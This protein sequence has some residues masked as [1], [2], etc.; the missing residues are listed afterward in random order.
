MQEGYGWISDRLPDQAFGVLVFIPF[1]YGFAV[2]EEF[3][4][5]LYFAIDEM[6]EGVDPAEGRQWLQKEQI[7]AVSLSYVV[8]LVS[9]YLSAQR[10]VPVQLNVPEDPVEKGEGGAGVCG[11]EQADISQ[12]DHGAGPYQQLDRTQLPEEE[13]EEHQG[14]QGIGDGDQHRPVCC[15]GPEAGG[16][17]I[18]FVPLAFLWRCAGDPRQG[19]DTLASLPKVAA[20][21]E[22][23]KR[24][25]QSQQGDAQQEAPVKA[26]E[27]PVGQEYPV[28][29]E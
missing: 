3:M 24:E 25:G 2:G 18:C 26:M 13:I 21:G 20:E 6:K 16:C 14:Y 15:G 19:R 5:D 11:S 4:D 17:C 28:V 23:Y 8:E 7:E 10:A 12:P 27:M 29:T 22:V 1:G 9:K